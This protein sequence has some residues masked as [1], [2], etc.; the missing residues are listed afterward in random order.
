M[1]KKIDMIAK[2]GKADS[3]LVK[4]LGR[5]PFMRVRHTSRVLTKYLSR[6]PKTVKDAL[7]KEKFD[8]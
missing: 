2:N 3:E 8:D 7:M 1:F 6:L 5:Q 4:Q